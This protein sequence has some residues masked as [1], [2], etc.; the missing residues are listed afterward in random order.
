MLKVRKIESGCR[1][2]SVFLLPGENWDVRLFLK[3]NR[4]KRPGSP[5]LFLTGFIRLQ[6]MGGRQMKLVRSGCGAYFCQKLPLTR[7]ALDCWFLTVT[8][9]ILM[10]TSFI[11]VR[12][13]MWSSYFYLLIRLIS[14]SLLIWQ[15]SRLLSPRSETRYWSFRTLMTQRPSKNYASYHVTIMPESVALNHKWF[16]VAGELLASVLIIRVGS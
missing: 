13:I 9:D 12:S 2:S 6:R 8:A 16:G 15:V 3:E 1:L 4:Y 5:H 11:R 10:W 14:Y 7:R